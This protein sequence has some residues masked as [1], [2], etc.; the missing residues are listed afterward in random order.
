MGELPDASKQQP[1][2]PS[3]TTKTQQSILPKQFDYILISDCF[4]FDEFR[5]PLAT[6]ISHFVNL[7]PLTK[8][9]LFGPT[10]NNTFQTFQD[11]LNDTLSLNLS[12]MV[13]FNTSSDPILFTT[14]NC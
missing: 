1:L 9:L 4:F 10:R 13:Q 12:E 7:N 2:D 6:C 8:I 5:E 11:L 3:N 14:Y